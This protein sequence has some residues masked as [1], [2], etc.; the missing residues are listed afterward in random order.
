V[1][2]LPRF[3]DGRIRWGRIL[4]WSGI[5]AGVVVI[6]LCVFGIATMFVVESR[7]MARDNPSLWKTPVQLTNSAIS[8]ATGKKLSYLGYEFEVPWIDLNEQHTKLVGKWQVIGFD[9]KRAIVLRTRPAKETV[10]FFSDLGKSDEAGLERLWGADT[11]VSDYT[12]TDAE[13]EATPANETLFTP[14]AQAVRQLLLLDLKSIRLAVNDDPDRIFLVNTKEFQGFQY[15]D[16]NTHP[17]IIV[18][19][20]YADSGS[21]DLEFR[22]FK[23]GPAITQEE[24]NRVIQ[25]VH[26]LRP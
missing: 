7:S 9:S 20:L 4:I 13:L 11:L 23:S 22:N 21:L 5:G 24:I 10:K 6:Y 2:L 18:D 15:G 25:T 17:R 1:K 16:P 8:S 26:T 19:S 3:D 12:F 14:R